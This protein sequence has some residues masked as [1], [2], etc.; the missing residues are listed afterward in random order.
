VLRA[1][2]V[3]DYQNVH[4]TAHDVFDLSGHQHDSLIDPMA[5]A[6]TAVRV[7]NA[8][9]REGFSLAQL[10]RVI[11]F[12]GLHHV[13]YDWEQ[14][15]RCIDQ[16]RQWRKDGAEVDLRDLKYSFEFGADGSPVL[17]IYGK[18]I[19][20]GRPKE[21]GIDVLC[22]I[23][24]IR[25]SFRSDIDLVILAT[26]DT[27]LIPALDELYDLRGREPRL[28]AQVETV[29]WFNSNAVAE[30]NYTGGNLR[31]TAPRRIW[32]TNLDRAAFVASRD[33]RDY[34]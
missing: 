14:N 6:R 12:R 3:I 29:A 33:T 22:A 23:S 34:R 30:G 24:C 25:E 26:R 21:K 11:A 8:K 28:Y 32:N 1:S 16:S 2:V 7:R 18:K 17:D 4:L 9:Q 13:E 10:S 27:D 5:F 31:P 20:K 19:P 15:R